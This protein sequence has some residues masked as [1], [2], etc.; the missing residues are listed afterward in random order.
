MLSLVK[1]VW[2]CWLLSALDRKLRTLCS[3]LQ[4][5]AN[6]AVSQAD[7]KLHLRL[8]QPTIEC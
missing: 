8:L 6:H 5:G 4:A 1:S 3:L 7:R 2:D